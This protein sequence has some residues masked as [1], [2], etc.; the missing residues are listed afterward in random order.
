MLASRKYEEL[1][2]KDLWWRRYLEAAQHGF[3][4][5]LPDFIFKKP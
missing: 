4:G 5:M 3:K 1:C 2:K